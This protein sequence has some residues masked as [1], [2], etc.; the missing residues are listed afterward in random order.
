LNG[1]QLPQQHSCFLACGLA[2][3]PTAL[4]PGC[5]LLLLLLL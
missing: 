3:V 5:L 4:L 1:C 2:L